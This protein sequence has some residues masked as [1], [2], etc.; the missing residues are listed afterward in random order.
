MHVPAKIIKLSPINTG[1][2]ADFSAL[3]K[4][5]VGKVSYGPGG[6]AYMGATFDP[7]GLYRMR[8]VF[9]W[10]KDINLNV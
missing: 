10:M 6:Q 2:L 4:A 1:W 5:Q 8:A 3:E 9:R 7:S